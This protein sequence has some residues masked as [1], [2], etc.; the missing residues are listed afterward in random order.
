VASFGLQLIV[1]SECF[2]ISPLRRYVDAF[3][4]LAQKGNSVIIPANVG[5]AGAM[6]AQA[7]AVYSTV[8]NSNKKASS[9]IAEEEGEGDDHHVPS[10][11]EVFNKD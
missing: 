2:L 6:V 9:S 7:M 11:K 4:K 1:A 8:V 10:I 3:S 5:D